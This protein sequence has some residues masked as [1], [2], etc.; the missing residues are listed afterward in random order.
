ML[1]G[2]LHVLHIPVMILQG[3][4][5]IHKLCIGCL[6]YTSRYL[7]VGIANLVNIFFPEVIALGG[8]I[9]NQGETLLRPLRA[10]VQSQ[11]DV[12]KRQDSG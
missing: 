5:H 12:Y 8:G 6:L 1:H 3:L 9:A 10:Q 2:E 4:A 11:E 7:G